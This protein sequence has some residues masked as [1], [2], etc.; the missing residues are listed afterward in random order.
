MC[1]CVC[2]GACVHVRVCVC[3]CGVWVR[4]VTYGWVSIAVGFHCLILYEQS[5]VTVGTLEYMY[6]YMQMPVFML[7]VHVHVYTFCF[8]CNAD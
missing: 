7:C 3:V 1:V 2:V 8:L 5:F 6:M 4:C